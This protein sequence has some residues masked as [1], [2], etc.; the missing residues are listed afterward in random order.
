MKAQPALTDDRV[1]NVPALSLVLPCYREAEH[2]DS[3]VPR[4]LRVLADLRYT[5]EIIFVDDCSPDDTAH[6]LER[7]VAAYPEWS[8]TILRHSRNL[9]RGAAVSTGFRAARG[10]WVGYID[11][12]LEVA[13]DYIDACCRVLAEGADVC[14]GARYYPFTFGSFIRFVASTGYR[15]LAWRILGLPE[16][17]S[18]S[19]YKFFRRDSV[20]PLLEQVLSTGWFWDTEIVA[21]S[22][23]A[24]LLVAQTPCLHLRRLD[25]TSTVKLTRDTWRF[26]VQLV[27]YRARLAARGAIPAR[28]SP[29][30]RLFPSLA[31]VA[32]P[33]PVSERDLIS[34]AGR[35]V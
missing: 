18:E 27:R 35:T 6:R 30:A 7:L 21:E 2:I 25:K 15:K 5:V 4:I 11:V 14:I 33:G 1:L 3:S 29:P 12:D 32:L 31:P 8:L 16:I 26:L 17:D 28:I 20:L 23:L 10:Q 13:P 9:G 24:G 19:G 34:S 22:Y